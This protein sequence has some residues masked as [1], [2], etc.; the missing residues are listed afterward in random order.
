[1]DGPSRLLLHGRVQADSAFMMPVLS[2]WHQCSALTDGE[3]LLSHPV[4]YAK[5]YDLLSEQAAYQA[6]L[7]QQAAAAQQLLLQQQGGGQ[8]IPPPPPK[9]GHGAYSDALA[10]QVAAQMSLTPGFYNNQNIN[11]AAAAAAAAAVQNIMSA[12]L[13]PLASHQHLQRL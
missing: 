12:R 6:A 5:S 9:F 3:F 7:T 1:M 10:A 13:P 4:E 11:A 8:Y 2:L